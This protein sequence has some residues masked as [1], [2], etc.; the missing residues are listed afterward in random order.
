MRALTL[1]PQFI[2]KGVS[3]AIDKFID[4]Q[5]VSDQQRMDHGAG[6]NFKR[7]DHEG[8]DYH[9]KNQ[10]YDNCLGIF[11]NNSA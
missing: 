5:V 1:D 7:L 2:V 3:Y 6:R 4:K 9:G 8:P 10:G 11:P